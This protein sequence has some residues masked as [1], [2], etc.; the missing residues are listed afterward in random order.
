MCAG[1]RERFEGLAALRPRLTRRLRSWGADHHAAE[2]LASEALL[3]VWRRLDRVPL[4]ADA[5]EAW[6]LGVARRLLANHNRA[7]GRRRRRTERFAAELQRDQVARRGEEAHGAG[8]LLLVTFGEAWGRLSRTDR[9]VLGLVARADRVSPAALGQ[10]LGCEPG[11]AATRLSRARARLR[12][13]L[14]G[15]PGVP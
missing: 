12:S 14:A 1:C 9:E 15:L 5:A 7:A 10:A 6:V 8:L 11:A 4:E 13:L 2:D 3:V